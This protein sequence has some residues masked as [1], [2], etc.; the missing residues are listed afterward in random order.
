M[1]P[2]QNILIH[3]EGE[4]IGGYETQLWELT[5]ALVAEQR[6]VTI[7]CPKGAVATLFRNLRVPVL[8]SPKTRDEWS[9]I[10]EKEKVTL[11]ITV[12][13]EIGSAATAAKR[14]GI[15]VFWICGFPPDGHPDLPSLRALA[16][17]LFDRVLVPSHFM[18][19]TVEN[20]LGAAAE[21]L[22]V[23]V[24]TNVFHKSNDRNALRL[25]MGIPY[26]AFV[27][28][29]A[30]RF[31]PHKRH[32]DLIQLLKKAHQDGHPLHLLLLGWGQE[33]YR[34]HFESLWNE[35]QTMN[36]LAYT[37]FVTVREDMPAF[38]SAMDV[39]VSPAQAEGLGCSLLEAM[40]CSVPVLIADSGGA[41]E[42]LKHPDAGKLFP[43]GETAELWREIKSLMQENEMASRQRS[44][45]ARQVVEKHF[46]CA[47]LHESFERIEA[48]L[49]NAAC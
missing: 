16:P 14:L 9:H 32:R 7:I 24:D 18:K 35:V 30:A 38:Y 34:A 5:R 11:L 6:S 47:S 23:G 33:R 42:V 19:K 25:S 8:P 3:L 27:V 22:T 31:A 21:V 37:H 48:S 36:L 41:P 17:L 12:Q 43:L 49:R 10:M 26:N 29:Y 13:G 20:I 40:A 1:K 4:A 2:N 44:F 15:A 39:F 45:H 46:S 28:G